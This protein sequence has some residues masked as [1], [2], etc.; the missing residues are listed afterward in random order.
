MTAGVVRRESS[1]VSR[2]MVRTRLILVL[3]FCFIV[4]TTISRRDRPQTQSSV[5]ALK[6]IIN[7]FLDAATSPAPERNNT[8]LDKSR[9]VFSFTKRS[10]QVRI[11]LTGYFYNI[12]IRIFQGKIVIWIF[13][14]DISYFGKIFSNSD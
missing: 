9:F 13:C 7:R 10:L 2:T 14:I 1:P 4:L 5:F 8:N 12:I 6:T 3:I 11:K